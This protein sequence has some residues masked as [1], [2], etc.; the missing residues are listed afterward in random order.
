[1]VQ[2]TLPFV[3][4]EEKIAAE[5]TFPTQGVYTLVLT[6]NPKQKTGTKLQFSHTQRVSRGISGT[7]DE[8]KMH[9]WAEIGFVASMSSLLLLAVV[10]FNKREDIAVYSKDN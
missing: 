7:T 1:M 5:Y 3:A 10:G 9:T 6:A 4:K 2:I 8:K